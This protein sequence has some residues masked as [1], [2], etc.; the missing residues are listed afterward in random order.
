MDGY[1]REWM[2]TILTRKP[3]C[4]KRF[5]ACWER[6]GS[7]DGGESEIRT[8]GMVE[9]YFSP[10]ELPHQTHRRSIFFGAQL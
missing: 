2:G 4:C 7:L 9:D 10:S 1:L 8:R 3:L 6:L 5:G